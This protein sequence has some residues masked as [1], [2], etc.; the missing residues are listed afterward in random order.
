MKRR[1]R[2]S[3]LGERAERLLDLPAGSLTSAPRI[4]LTGDR[5]VRIENGCRLRVCEEDRIALETACGTLWVR[6][7]RLC[8]TVL[9]ADSLTVCGHILSVEYAE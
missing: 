1:K 3:A 8:L 9:S 5:Q 6:G 7:G 4:E 2:P